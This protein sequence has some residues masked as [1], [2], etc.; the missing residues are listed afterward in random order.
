MI[1]VLEVYTILWYLEIALH[2]NFVYLD[3][4]TKLIHIKE[5]SVFWDIHVMLHSLLISKQHFWRIISPPSSRLKNKAGKRLSWSRWLY[6]PPTLCW[7]LACLIFLPRRWRKRVPQKCQLSFNRLH[8]I[9]SQKIEL[10]ITTA[11]KKL[12]STICNKVKWTQF[13]S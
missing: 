4:V 12:D 6:L 5:S 8:G 9:I 1:T 11:V 10:S 3:V 13:T 7:C 2:I